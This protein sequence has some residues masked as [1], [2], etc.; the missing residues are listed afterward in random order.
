MEEKT[1]GNEIRKCC[2]CGSD[3]SDEDD[4]YGEEQ[5][6]C[7]DCFDKEAIELR[8]QRKTANARNS[9]MWQVLTALGKIIKMGR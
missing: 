1:E 7:M 8:Q 9:L 6:V 4:R 5:N 3:I 2:R